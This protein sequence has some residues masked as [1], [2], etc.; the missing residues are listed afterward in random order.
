MDR[1]AGTRKVWGERRRVEREKR[2]ERLA[3]HT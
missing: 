2:E 3:L 1:K